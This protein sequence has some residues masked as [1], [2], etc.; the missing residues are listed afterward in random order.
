MGATSFISSRLFRS[1]R[2]GSLA[3]SIATAGVAAGVFVMLLSVSIVLGFQGEIRDKMSSFSGH[4]QVLSHESLYSPFSR[5]ITFSREQERWMSSQPH[6]TSVRHFALKEGMLKTDD[7]FRGIQLKGI[8]GDSTLNLSQGPSLRI[9]RSMARSLRV[10][11]GDRVF[12]YFFDGSLKA[13]RFT[14]VDIYETH[15][16]EFDENV[17]F[18]PLSRAAAQRLAER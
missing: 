13:R 15:L 8:D 2:T 5:P 11:Q 12:A 16:K 10:K 1:S 3:V 7:V 6:V 18:C 14:V 4:I 17:C 9:S